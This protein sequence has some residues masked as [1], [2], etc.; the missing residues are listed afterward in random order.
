MPGRYYGETSW[1]SSAPKRH[2]ASR[3]PYAR[4]VAAGYQAGKGSVRGARRSG[5]AGTV[6]HITARNR[7]FTR[8]SGF[9]GRYGPQSRAAGHAVELKFFD[10]VFNDA[11]ISA[12]G[13]VIPS[14]NLVAQGVTEKTRVGRKM[15][16]TYLHM[17]YTVHI[18]ELDAG[19]TPNPNDTVR[20][21]VY[22]DSQCNG[23]TAAV[24]D[25][26]ETADQMSFN[27]LGNSGRFRVLKDQRINLNYLSMASDGAGVVSQSQVA[28]TFS[29]HKK[30]NL[31]IEFDAAA[32]AI[33]EIRSNNIGV[34]WISSTGLAEAVQ[35]L[36]RI[37]FSDS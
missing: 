12:T 19:G 18:P 1:G 32:G 33:T 22:I 29:F 11:V 35:C 2:K 30:L 8:T 7:G 26:L 36:A 37:R 27:N 14:L 4:G 17:N 16:I 6:T 10:A 25:I 13:T 15:T 20:F 34:L 3:Y 23:A 24:L 9:Y 5:R 21:I 31:P 28:R